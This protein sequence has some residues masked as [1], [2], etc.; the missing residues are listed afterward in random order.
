ML[1]LMITSSVCF[2][3]LRLTSVHSS[4]RLTFVMMI[5]MVFP[6]VVLVLLTVM[7]IIVR[8]IQP[9]TIGKYEKEQEIKK[10]RK[11]MLTRSRARL[12]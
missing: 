11:R 7:F 5:V 9:S 3:V 1:S 2:S 4:C 10:A 8:H 6:F 12:N